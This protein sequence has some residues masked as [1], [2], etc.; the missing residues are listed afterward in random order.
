MIANERFIDLLSE[1]AT[2][3]LDVFTSVP[4]PTVHEVVRA[5][6][7]Q[8]FISQRSINHTWFSLTRKRECKVNWDR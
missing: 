2:C 7:V 6:N 5:P 3:S 8:F 1:A 4:T